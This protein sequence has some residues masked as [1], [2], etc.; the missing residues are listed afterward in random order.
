MD[1][2]NG[3]WE[4]IYDPINKIKKLLVKQKTKINYYKEYV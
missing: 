4:T 2:K 3:D 1:I